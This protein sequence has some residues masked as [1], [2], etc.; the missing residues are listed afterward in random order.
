MIV[1]KSAPM[2]AGGT[3]EVEAVLK[4][5]LRHGSLYY[6]L[7]WKDYPDS[8]NTWE[9][10][11]NL[12]CPDLLAAYWQG[13]AKS[14]PRPPLAPSPEPPPPPASEPPPPPSEPPPLEPLVPRAAPASPADTS[15]LR[16]LAPTGK[17]DGVLLLRVL[18]ANGDQTVWG[19]DFIKA[20]F[21]NLLLEF[22]ENHM[23]WLSS[24]PKAVCE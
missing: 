21:P 22:F 11:A 8:E 15:P 7:K 6:Y 13:Q 5:R 12:T 4:H 24:P 18:L 23:K 19:N 2:S 9:A 20:H 1:L 10:E 14:G 17:R 3:Y 16:I